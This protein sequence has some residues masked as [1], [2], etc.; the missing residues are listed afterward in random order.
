MSQVNLF[1]S[2]FHWSWCS[3]ST[4]AALTKTGSVAVTIYLALVAHHSCYESPCSIERKDAME[5]R[6]LEWF[7]YCSLGVGNFC[8][9]FFFYFIFLWMFKIF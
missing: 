1:L 4:I 7:V 3:I 2:N 8:G 6:M 5:K 9:F